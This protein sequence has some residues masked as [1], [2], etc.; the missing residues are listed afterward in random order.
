M[1]ASLLFLADIAVGSIGAVVATHVIFD[2]PVPQVSIIAPVPARPE[3]PM[4]LVVA[5]GLYLPTLRRR[6]PS[7]RLR[8]LRRRS[9]SDFRSW[10]LESE[11]HPPRHGVLCMPTRRC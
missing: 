4:P 6:P 10:L 8:R 7:C 11:W 2:A 3:Q 1:S 5:H 9:I